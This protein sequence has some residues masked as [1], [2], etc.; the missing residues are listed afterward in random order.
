MVERVEPEARGERGL[1]LPAIP[2]GAA[3]IKSGAVSLV[4][5]VPFEHAEDAFK[6]HEL[7]G[8]PVTIEIRSEP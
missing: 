1:S 6:I 2:Q 4:F 7:Q 3:S 8:K 5:H